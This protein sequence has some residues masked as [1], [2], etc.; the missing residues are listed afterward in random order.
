[1]P[2]SNVPLI[3]PTHVTDIPG[4][5][6]QTMRGAWVTRLDDGVM[7]FIEPASGE[8]H[9]VTFVDSN[10]GP[11]EAKVIFFPDREHALIRSRN[12]LA[13][14][15]FRGGERASIESPSKFD[16]IFVTQGGRY[17]W[18]LGYDDADLPLLYLFD[19]Y[20]LQL[21]DTHAPQTILYGNDCYDGTVQRLKR[22][23]DA[24]SE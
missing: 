3:T 22:W 23:E 4:D 9:R 5:L 16:H 11:P 1:M 15:H 8:I 12:K 20:T 6:V 18:G 10:F 17:L 13:L 14:R 24:Y 2:A 7:G 19:G 21:L